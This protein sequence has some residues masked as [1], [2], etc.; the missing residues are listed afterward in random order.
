M[1][2]LF[3]YRGIENLGVGY[4]MSILR[5]HGHEIDLVFDPGLDDN[6][7]VKAPRLAWLNR[8]E[9]LLERAAAF[10]PDLIAMGSLTNLYPFTCA[11]AEKLK[12]RI[13]V[14]IIVGGH[15]AQALPDYV[16]ANPHVDMVCVGEGELA[17]LELVRRMERGEDITTIPTLWVKRAG[18][19]HQNALGP[20]E[21]DL[22]RFPFPEKQL[23][24]EYGCF[25]DNLEIFTGRGCP[26]KCTFCNIHY[27][28]AIFDGK[29]D[30]LRKRSVANVMA[31]FRQNLAR[32]DV[33]FVS[34]HDDNFTTDARWVEEFCEAYRREVNLPWYCFGYPT[35]I[36]PRLVKA[37]KAAN[38]ATI[39]MGVDSGDPEI[40]RHLMERPMTDELIFRSARLIQDAGIGLQVSCIYG[41]PGETPEQMLKTLRMVDAIRPTQSS[42]Y[43]FYSFPKTK[44]HDMAVEMGQ[45]DEEGQEKVRRGI[46]GYHH[47]SILKHP[48][49]ELAETLA[50]ITPVYARTP[51]ALKPVLRWMI[52]WRMKRLALLLYVCLIPLTF[53]FLGV[54]GIKVTLRMAWR[55]LRGRGAP[56]HLPA[57]VIPTANAA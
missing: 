27:Q 39:F 44:L 3:Y 34:V 25:R 13:G 33:S 52:A 56:R 54:E 31:E 15:H 11:M 21:N 57:P 50:K 4:L 19:I 30:F 29:G 12:E 43:V 46:S 37:M 47:E 36:K 22:D 14:P 23:W 55:A 2:V 6:L 48:H 51:E 53:P 17:L 7:F 10:R 35:T 26:F 38:C 40:R 42:A 5:H 28:R 24:W 41:N 1:R 49:K 16:L 8:H 18:Q 9:A 45:L 20:L 32:Y